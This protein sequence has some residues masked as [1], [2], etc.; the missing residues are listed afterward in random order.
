MLVMLKST[1]NFWKT[2]A[3][4]LVKRLKIIAQK[5]KTTK[6]PNPVDRKSVTLEHLKT[7]RKLSRNMRQAKTVS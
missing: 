2:K 4:K 7:S 3:K 6:S 1:V 5:L